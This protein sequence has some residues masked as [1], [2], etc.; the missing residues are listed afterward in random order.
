MQSGWTAG[1][2]GV[3]EPR[4]H[5]S[6]GIDVPMNRQASLGCVGTTDCAITRHYSLA[7][8]SVGARLSRQGAR[9]VFLLAQHHRP[10]NARRLVRQ[11]H[12]YDRRCRGHACSCRCK[13]P[14][15]RR[16]PGRHRACVPQMLELPHVA[17]ELIAREEIQMR[18]IRLFAIAAAMVATGVGV[19]AAS[20]TNARVAPSMVQGIEP[21]QLM[22]NAKGLATAEFADYTFVFH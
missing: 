2:D 9:L 13:R 16:S 6:S 11:R 20:T 10:G 7:S 18:T 14:W 12:G 8:S 5:H 17:G 3:R 4:P 1:P 22:M 21:L 19:W 15:A